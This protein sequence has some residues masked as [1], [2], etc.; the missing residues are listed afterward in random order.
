MT[1]IFNWKIQLKF[2]T[3]RL[4]VCM[5]VCNTHIWICPGGLVVTDT[6][7]LILYESINLECCN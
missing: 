1:F 5:C 2:R 7:W 6:L 4:L 3:F